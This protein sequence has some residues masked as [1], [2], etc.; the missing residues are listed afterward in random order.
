MKLIITASLAVLIAGAALADAPKGV[1]FTRPLVGA[2]GQPMRDVEQATSADPQCLKC[3][4]LNFGKVVG[5]CLL[6]QPRQ[7]QGAALW[8][9]AVKVAAPDAK[10]VVLDTAEL[11]A[12]ESMP[13]RRQASGSDE[14]ANPPRHRSDL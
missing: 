13:R 11:H 14:R 6:Q 7:G 5:N 2:D 1:D 8:A 9:L 4:P 10:S 12:I 3:G